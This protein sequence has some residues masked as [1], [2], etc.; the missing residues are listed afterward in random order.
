MK[1]PLVQLNIPDEWIIN[2]NIFTE[3][4]PEK[5]QDEDYEYRLEFNEDILQIIN[6]HR[7]RIIDLGWY[8]E[9]NVNGQ[10]RLMVIEWTNDCEQQPEFWDHPLIKYCSRDIEDIKK[11]IEGLAKKVTEGQI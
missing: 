3:A 6:T 5:F 2:R 7:R 4:S 1:L 9:F 8:P 11:K 10:Y